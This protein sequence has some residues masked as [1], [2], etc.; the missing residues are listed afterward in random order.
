MVFVASMSR[1]I[2]NNNICK[3][4]VTPWRELG[5]IHIYMLSV[6]SARVLT[7]I[8][9]L[10]VTPMLRNI[11]IYMLSIT[12]CSATPETP[13][14]IKV[15]SPRAHASQTVS[16]YMLSVTLVSVLPYI[17]MLL[18]TSMSRTFNIHMLLV[19]CNREYTC[20]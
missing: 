3:V 16:I 10:F 11:N 20:C 12:R 13:V 17:Y 5:N 7:H 19:T 9:T 6:T 4:F 8:C 18:A 15:S 14:F 1:V 2:E